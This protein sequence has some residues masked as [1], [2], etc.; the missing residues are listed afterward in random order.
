MGVICPT[1]EKGFMEWK[2]IHS[3]K[4]MNKTLPEVFPMFL[5]TMKSSQHTY[6]K[7]DKLYRTGE[8]T[9]SKV[10]VS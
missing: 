4:Y 8:L 1:L 10:I 2:I 3:K 5:F 9:L 7:C 6:I